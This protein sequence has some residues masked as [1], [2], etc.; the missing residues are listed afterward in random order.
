MLNVEA[1]PYARVPIIK[2]K[3]QDG[4]DFVFDCDLSVNNVL[5]CINTDLLFTYTMLDKRVRPLI[6]CIKHWVKQR[7]IHKTFRGYLSSYTYTLMVIQYL[8]YERVLPCLQ[9]LRRVQ[10]TLNNDPSFAVSC[11]GDV[12]DCYFYRNVETLASFGERNNRSSL[13]LLL[14][15]FFHFYSNVF[16][17][18]KGVVSIRS[19]RLLRKKAKGWD[20]SEDF[21]NRHIFCIEDPFD[22]NLDLGRYVNDYTVQ[23]ILEEF[24]RAL[25]V[26]QTSGSFAEV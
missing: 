12:Y 8:Q 24:A 22:I 19:G 9:S 21:R 1:L 13:G 11:D 18:D 3:A 16:P 6:M 7:R 2:F 26:L 15:G 5:A 4:L 10:A 25:Q 23:D 20:T 14:V 17:I